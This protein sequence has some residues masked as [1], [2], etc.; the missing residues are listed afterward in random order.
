MTKKDLTIDEP[1]SPETA[2]DEG[3]F[4]ALADRNRR[5]LLDR[6]FEQDGQ[7]LAALCET[8]CMSRQAV[9]KHLGILEAANLITSLSNGRHKY[10]YLNPLPITQIN[11]RWLNKF[12]EHQANS[13]SALKTDV[14]STVVRE[15]KSGRSAGRHSQSNHRDGTK[16]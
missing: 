5:V 13:L 12:T 2:E 10:H 1:I 4:R 14:E 11:Q 16:Q 9:S 15:K 7:T 3:V 6:L 8:L